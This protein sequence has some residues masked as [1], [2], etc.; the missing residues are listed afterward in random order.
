MNKK[1]LDIMNLLLGRNMT[2][3][4]HTLIDVDP[5]SHQCL[6]FLGS[7]SLRNP[8]AGSFIQAIYSTMINMVQLAVSDW[9]IRNF[10]EFS[11]SMEEID[12]IRCIFT[13]FQKK[14][15]LQN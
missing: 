11:F 12:P 1:L 3:G 6:A 8:R 15:F 4:L 10:K 13:Y 7:L 5:Y 2:G 9:P 14:R